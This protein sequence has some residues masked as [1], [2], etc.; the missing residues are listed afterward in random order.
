MR[1]RQVLLGIG[2]AS[3]AGRPTWADAHNPAFLSAAQAMDGS[4]HLCGLNLAGEELFTIPLPD[5]GH[6]AAAH[7]FR[8]EAIAFA[9]RPGRFGIILDCVTGQEISRLVPPADRHFYGHGV[10]SADGATLFT[11]ENDL[12]TL[13]GRI[14]LWD[15]A[16]G[17]TRIGDI[18]SGG[19][20]PH[21]IARLPGTDTLVVANGGIA[22]HPDSGRA[23]L[24]LATMRANLAYI[25]PDLAIGEVVELDIALRQNSIRH[26]DVRAD[27]LVAA[28][29]QWNGSDGDF[30]PLVMVHRRGREPVLMEGPVQSHRQMDGYVGSIA[31]MGRGDQVGV[32]SPRGGL[33]QVFDPDTGAF[34]ADLRLEDTCGIARTREGQTIATSGLGAIGRVQ[35]GSFTPIRRSTMAWD[36]HLV[37]V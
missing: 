36:N 19:V 7:P 5:R 28:G 9:R 12:E 32:T 22:T 29:M 6:A 11:T 2:A 26:L 15:A 14:G 10:F 24:N 25:D 8:A 16:S 34:V 3:L 13:E 30:P 37:A 35:E 17:Y 23:P 4:Y 1:R 18:P 31:F 27:G 21:D 33:I 20:G